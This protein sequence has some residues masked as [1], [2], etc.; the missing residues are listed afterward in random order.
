MSEQE[1][2]TV[3]DHP[4]SPYAQKVKIALLEKG[5]PFE[6]PLPEA[7]GSGLA[8]G[9][10]IAANPRGEVP[11]LIDGDVAIFDSTIILEYIEDRWP[12]PPLLPA[13][14]AERARVRMIEDVMDTHYEAISWGLAE[15]EHFG[16][17]E[18]ELAATLKGAAAEQTRAWQAWLTTQLGGKDWFNGEAFG[19]GD[20]SVIPYVNGSAGFGLAPEAG[21]PLAAWMA[22]ANAR[23]SVAE[24]T[25][26]AAAM[27]FGG[28]EAARAGMAA[29]R[30]MLER[31]EFRREYRDHRLEWMIRSGGMQVV[32]DG[33]AA[34]NIRFTDAFPA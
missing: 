21:S 8:G 7:M 33:L 24:V 25:A 14:P 20:L 30:A 3:Y 31:G 19:W 26:A 29:V 5:V 2:V 18:G 17:A 13:A 28:T 22:R 11:A 4:L 27:S 16:R 34:N 32:L 23:P 9:P 12:T 6:A 15:L 10:F 1:T